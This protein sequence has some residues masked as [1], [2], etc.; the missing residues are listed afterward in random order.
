[1]P[2][3]KALNEESSRI[4]KV[5]RCTPFSKCLEIV[6]SFSNLSFQFGIY[7]IKSSDGEILYIGKTNSFRTRFQGGHQALVRILLAGHPP[8]SIR[9]LTVTSTERFADDLLKLERNLLSIHAP[10]YNSRIPD[11]LEVIKMVQLKTPPVSGNIKHLLQYLPEQIQQQLEDHADHYGIPEQKILEQ[12]IAFFLDPN[13]TTL[14]DVEPDARGLG[15]LSE[16][17]E[18]LKAENEALKLR[19]RLLGSEGL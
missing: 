10:R 9:I 14:H 6:P 15:Q 8:E 13:G 11:V 18:I 17:N 19:L 2:S 4:N 7:A 3:L 5:L 12:A 1:M 16:E